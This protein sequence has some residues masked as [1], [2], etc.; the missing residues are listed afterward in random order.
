MANQIVRGRRLLEGGAE[1]RGMNIYL[2]HVLI[3]V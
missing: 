3:P 1:S 2:P